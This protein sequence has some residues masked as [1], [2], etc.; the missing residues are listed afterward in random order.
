MMLAAVA[1]SIIVATFA[2]MVMIRRF[3]LQRFRR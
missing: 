1:L 3:S 2:G